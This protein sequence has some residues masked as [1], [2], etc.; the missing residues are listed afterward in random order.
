MRSRLFLY[1]PFDIEGDETCSKSKMNGFNFAF[2]FLSFFLS[3]KEALFLCVGMRA[4]PKCHAQTS[5]PAGRGE[6]MRANECHLSS[7]PL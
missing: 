2:F 5:Q 6:T 1:P 3:L 4:I 7:L